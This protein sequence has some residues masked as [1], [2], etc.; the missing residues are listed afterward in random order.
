MVIDNRLSKDG[1][2]ACE[3]GMRMR[4][5]RMSQEVFCDVPQEPTLMT[6]NV[7]IL[8]V[9]FA[10]IS[11]MLMDRKGCLLTILIGMIDGDCEQSWSGNVGRWCHCFESFKV[12][13][14]NHLAL[15]C[16]STVSTNASTTSV[17]SP[18]QFF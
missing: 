8:A 9:A 16:R 17:K 11:G 1:A 13:S 18:A 6:R 5:V 3:I 14:C 10:I 4:T 12:F 15:E 7:G 2:A